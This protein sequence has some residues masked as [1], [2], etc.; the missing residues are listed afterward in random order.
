MTTS[1]KLLVIAASAL[2]LATGVKA[3]VAIGGY[4]AAS[5]THT[6]GAA[7]DRLDIDSALL[8]F[9][10]DSKPVQGVV[11]LFYAPGSTFFSPTAT[12]ADIHVLDAYVNWDLGSGWSLTG[13]RF[14][15]WMGYESFFTVNN[16][17]ITGANTLAVIPGYEEGLR[18]TYTEK[19]WNAGFG[20]VDSAYNPVTPLRG[21]GE[22]KSTYAI[23]A[24]L[25]Y[26]GVKDLTVWLGLAYEPQ[27]GAAKA[28]AT[29]DLWAQY[30][31]SKELYVAGEFTVEDNVVGAT[32]DSETWLI[33][34][35]YMFDDKV[36][37]AARVS[38]DTNNGPTVDDVKW[39][40][41]PTYT[42]SKNFS[43]RAE[44]SY[45]VNSGKAAADATSIG[46]Q[47]VFRF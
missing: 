38:G 10:G 30:Q 31:V 8:K 42:V 28:K 17:E 23:E 41:A 40:L 12:D 14:L 7:T 33:L 34:A 22:W 47:G 4:A 36:S 18:V 29:L 45:L 3:Q 32:A 43:V 24:Y 2:A 13:G 20:V 39:T 35:N 26:G 1:K 37:V 19:D 9:T 21:D 16:P 46:V 25:S 27:P 15:S 11:S 5:W 6:S 44:I